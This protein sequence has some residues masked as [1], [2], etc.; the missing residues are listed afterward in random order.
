MMEQP[1]CLLLKFVKL[2]QDTPVGVHLPLPV[3]S[4]VL[5]RP[6]FHR[7]ILISL[8]SLWSC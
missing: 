3:C 8:L 6:C 2:L 1:Q 5:V 4:V 7:A